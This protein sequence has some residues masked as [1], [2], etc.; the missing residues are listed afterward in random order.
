MQTEDKKAVL[1][2]AEKGYYGEGNSHDRY[3]SPSPVKDP[4][5]GRAE[6]SA[7]IKSAASSYKRMSE[8]DTDAVGRGDGGSGA[9]RRAIPG[10]LKR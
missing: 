7:S 1:D 4:S 3:E 5:N 2:K 8:S 6:R 9:G 10:S